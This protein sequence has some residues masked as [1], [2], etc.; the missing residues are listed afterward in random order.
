MPSD[1]KTL[2]Q[3]LL[4]IRCQL[5]EPAAFDELVDRWHTPLWRYVR[6]MTDRNELAE[7]LLQE[8]WLRVLRGMVKLRE[9]ASLVPWLFGIAR[10]VLMDHLRQKYKQATTNDAAID[11]HAAR[12]DDIDNRDDIEHLLHELERL[13]LPQRELVTL[14]YLEELTMDEVASVLDIPA[15]TVKSRLYHVRNTLKQTLLNEET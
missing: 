13:P 8:T 7:E 14:Y 5:G 12:T 4:A 3:E 9:P 6:R 11:V 2:Q 10:R 15:G 1:P